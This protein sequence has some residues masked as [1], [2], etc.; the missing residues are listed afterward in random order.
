MKLALGLQS[1][2]THVDIRCWL[3]VHCSSRLRTFV[4]R[5][6][7]SVLSTA[8]PKPAQCLAYA[9]HSGVLV[10]EW[11]RLLDEHERRLEGTGHGH[12]ATFACVVESHPLSSW[13]PGLSLIFPLN[14]W[15]PSLHWAHSRQP[16]LCSEK[17]ERLTSFVN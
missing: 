6:L 14:M 17:G 11:G 15:D 3:M 16:S 9:T 1:E 13:S 4:G 2:K 10:R 7:P 8:V 12:G 5:V